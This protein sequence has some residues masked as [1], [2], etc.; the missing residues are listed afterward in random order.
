[1]CNHDS[2]TLESQTADNWLFEY[3]TVG[4]ISLNAEGKIQHVN[5]CIER[6]FDYSAKELAGRDVEILISK[7]YIKKY[8]KYR[9]NYFSRPN[10]IVYEQGIALRALR[11]C[12]S[13]FPVE[14][15]LANC[16]KNQNVGVA[17]VTYI[18]DCIGMKKEAQGKDVL[19]KIMA[20]NAPVLIWVSGPDKFRTYFNNTWLAFTGRGLEQ[21]IGLGWTDDIHPD[22]KDRFLTIYNKAFEDRNPYT[23]EYR[24]RRHDNQY[25]WMLSTGKP[26]FSKGNSFRGFIGSSYEIHS[27]KM[28]REELETLLKKHTLE[29]TKSLERE[30]KLNK[31]KS[32]FVSMASHELRTPLSAIS[33]SISLIER[34]S[35]DDQKASR[36]K[37]LN[38]IKLSIENLMNILNDFFSIDKLDQG[39]L[40]VKKQ[41]FNL[42]GLVK[43]VIE[44]LQQILKE[45]QHIKYTHRGDEIIVQDK[46]IL[47]NVLV[48]LLSNAIKYS[49]KKPVYLRVEV[50]D[51]L[52]M[53]IKDHG[54]GIPREEQP[55]LF[56]RFYRAKNAAN[57]QGTGLGL[58]IVKKYVRLLG[59][60]ITYVSNPGKGTTFVVKFPQGKN[61]Y[62]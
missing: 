16:Q 33:S 32:R 42:V 25:R 21:E 2:T 1:M 57:I 13:S 35:N 18:S 12:G 44:E 54:I 4:I 28:M 37:H 58:N 47:R 6:W 7:R 40:E 15:S 55:N 8:I 38:R 26:I 31:L 46:T 60:H 59:G 17:F 10:T 29:L 45:G 11:K 56:K 14:I 48:N 23:M 3:A 5:P 43:S 61:L 41:Q 34:Y 53:H 50:F 39:K 9:N 19:F 62:N 36:E 20:E 49:D 30:K 52:V 24:L 22:D 51:S 27:Q